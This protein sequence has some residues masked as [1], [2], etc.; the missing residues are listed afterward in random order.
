MAFSKNKHLECVLSSHN[1]NVGEGTLLD[2]HKTKRDKVKQALKDHYGS[3]QK[4]IIHS[5]SYAKHTAINT[6]FDLDLCIYFKKDAF[7]RLEEMHNDVYEFLKNDYKK[8]DTDLI[9]V[10]K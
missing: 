4:K 10:R 8:S 2:N 7:K 5:G 3:N 6:K 1:M 9:E